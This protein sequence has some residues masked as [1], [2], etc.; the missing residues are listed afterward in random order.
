METLKIKGDARTPYVYFSYDEGFLEISGRAV[1]EDSY[2]VFKPLLKWVEEYAL[3]PP[4]VNTTVIFKLDF[5]NTS[6]STFI[7]NILKTFDRLSQKGY[8]IELRWYYDEYDDDMREYGEDYQSLLSSLE[9]D[10]ILAGFE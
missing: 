8:P 4:P 2:E 1:P 6:S 5:F 7:V 10:I 9:M 3:H